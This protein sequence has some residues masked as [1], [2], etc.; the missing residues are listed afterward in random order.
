MTAFR[1]GWPLWCVLVVAASVASAP[2]AVGAEL[3]VELGAWMCNKG[4]MRAIAFRPDGKLVALAGGDGQDR[5]E[6]IASP[7]AERTTRDVTT[8]EKLATLEGHTD[9]V[10]TVAFS[11]DSKT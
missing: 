8:R 1:S 6:P 9:S 10:W 3:T 2:R 5:N 7:D 4:A 11:P